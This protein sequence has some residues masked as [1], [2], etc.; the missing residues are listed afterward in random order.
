MVRD[1]C[2]IGVIARDSDGANRRD[3]CDGARWARDE[4]AMGARWI[5]AL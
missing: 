5:E 4:R 2:A 3:E 1:S